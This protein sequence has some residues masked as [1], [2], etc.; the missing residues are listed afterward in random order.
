M[1]FL[2]FCKRIVNPKTDF[3]EFVNVKPDDEGN[4][5][6]PEKYHVPVKSIIDIVRPKRDC[7]DRIEIPFIEKTFETDWAA[8][9]ENG[10]ETDIPDGMVYALSDGIY[11]ECPEK[12]NNEQMSI[13]KVISTYIIIQQ[14]QRN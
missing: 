10:K 1:I 3:S 11:D 14:S 2:D 12:L 8:L 5:R 13:I 6:F 9:L 7:L 4:I